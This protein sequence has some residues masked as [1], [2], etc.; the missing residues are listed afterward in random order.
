M[1]QREAKSQ[2]CL[3][4]NKRKLVYGHSILANVY[5]QIMFEFI[6]YSNSNLITCPIKM[7]LGQKIPILSFERK[8]T[9]PMYSISIF[10]ES[11]L[12][13]GSQSPRG[14]SVSPREIGLPKV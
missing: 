11:G 12:L 10:M 4:T 13:E 9:N 14:K 3:Y 8:N 1:T 6:F 2:E 7:E 5:I